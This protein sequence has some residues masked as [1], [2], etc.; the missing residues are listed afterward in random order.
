MIFPFFE[1]PK[2]MRIAL[3]GDLF[4]EVAYIQ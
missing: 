2:E 1:R 4:L 3:S